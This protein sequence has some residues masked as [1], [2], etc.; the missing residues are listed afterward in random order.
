MAVLGSTTANVAEFR[1]LWHDGAGYE[2]S[3]TF[4]ITK[5][6]SWTEHP[7][8]PVGLQVIRN[9]VD[10]AAVRVFYGAPPDLHEQVERAIAAVL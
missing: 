2:S 1:M 6:S 10:V 8:G 7:Y 4:R 9:T 3:K 5:D